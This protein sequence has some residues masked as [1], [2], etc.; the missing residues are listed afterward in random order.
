MYTIHQNPGF[1][2]DVIDTGEKNRFFW[3]FTKDFGFINASAQSVRTVKSKLNS[4]LQQ[5][6]FSIIEFVKGKDIWK[7]TNALPYNSELF[8]FS[9]ITKHGQESIVRIAMLLK[10][11]YVGEEAHDYLFSEVYEACVKIAKTFDHETI[12]A[13]EIL[14]TIKILYHL[15]YWEED[16]TSYALHLSPFTREILDRTRQKKIELEERIKHSLRE[17]HL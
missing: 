17:S 3:I 8:I 10:R 15:G 7:I 13:I 6:S 4:R 11:L 2:I 5:Y 1:I 9:E 14:L 12:Q 16:K